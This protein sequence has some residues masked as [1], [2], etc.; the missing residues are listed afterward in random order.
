MG[1]EVFVVKA[2]PDKIKNYMPMI[3]WPTY[4]AMHRRVIW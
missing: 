4:Q 2:V 1:A 3:R